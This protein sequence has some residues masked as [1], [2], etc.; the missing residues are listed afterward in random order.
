MA[1]ADE[2]KK[3]AGI[4]QKANTDDEFRQKLLAN[5]AEVLKQ[6]GI[7]VHDADKLAVEYHDNYGLYIGLPMVPENASE[8]P[9]DQPGK[10]DQLNDCLH[11]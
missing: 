6:H 9:A 8:Q 10:F 11:Y 5:P 1:T 2:C 3:L 4:Y 7:E